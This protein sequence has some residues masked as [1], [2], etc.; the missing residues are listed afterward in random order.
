MKE[1]SE[2]NNDFL[3]ILLIKQWVYIIKFQQVVSIRCSIR[4]YALHKRFHLGDLG[5]SPSGGPLL[6]KLINFYYI[7]YKLMKAF[8]VAILGSLI[9][10]TTFF[11][12][13]CASLYFI[14]QKKHKTD[15]KL[16]K[17]LV[18]IGIYQILRVANWIIFATNMTSMH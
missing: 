14:F 4:Q 5:S 13:A 12:F 3:V 11:I 7:F 2:E 8:I 15:T 17:L 6:L 18:I 9:N 10:M 1:Y 16:Y